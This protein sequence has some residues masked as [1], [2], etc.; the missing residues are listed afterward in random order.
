MGNNDNNNWKIKVKI[1][2][3]QYDM[4]FYLLWFFIVFYFYKYQ[5]CQPINNKYCIDLFRV[6]QGEKDINKS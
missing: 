2:F 5:K 4:N 6:L 1:T 3:N